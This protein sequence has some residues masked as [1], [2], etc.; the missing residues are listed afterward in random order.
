LKK[1]KAIKHHPPIKNIP[2][3]G[4]LG[5]LALGYIG[6]KLWRIQRDKKA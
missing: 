1:S 4:S 5:L 6:L 2:K 3:E